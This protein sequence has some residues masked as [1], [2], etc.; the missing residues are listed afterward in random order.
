MPQAGV[1]FLQKFCSKSASKI[2]RQCYIRKNDLSKRAYIA[3]QLNIT[4]D[5]FS[6]CVIQ[7]N[8]Y[9]ENQLPPSHTPTPFPSC[10]G[11]QLT[12]LVTMSPEPF[13]LVQPQHSLYSPTGRSHMLLPVNKCR[14][15][16]NHTQISMVAQYWPTIGNLWW[17]T[18][19]SSAGPTLAHW[20]HYNNGAIL[21]HR[22][23][24][25]KILAKSGPMLAQWIRSPTGAILGWHICYLR[26]SQ[27]EQ[28]KALWNTYF[29]RCCILCTVIQGI[30]IRSFLKWCKWIIISGHLC[31]IFK[32][33]CMLFETP[34]LL[35][36]FH[37]LLLVMV[38]MNKLI[39]R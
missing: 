22:L 10:Y 7:K 35:W 37:M 33:A 39:S 30:F 36:H 5:V 4:Q 21:V 2:Q 19:F 34:N 9:W 11:R 23:D 3:S 17:T 15:N 25:V 1:S 24:N 29:F 18:I 38:F 32:I 8:K 31:E 27:W 14:D 28:L 26:S 20:W 12:Q 6:F 13:H 16:N